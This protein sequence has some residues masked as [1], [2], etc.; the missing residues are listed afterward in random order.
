LKLNNN[1]NIFTTLL[2]RKSEKVSCFFIPKR[3][4]ILLSA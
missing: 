2:S 1:N 3:L 4:K